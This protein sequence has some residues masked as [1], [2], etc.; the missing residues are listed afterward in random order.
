DRQRRART[1]RRR[2]AGDRPARAGARGIQQGA[3][4]AGRGRAFAAAAGTEAAGCRWPRVR[5]GGADLTMGRTTMMKR[6]A[7]LAVLVLA[8]A[9][10][11]T[12]KG[13]FGGKDAAA[14]KAAEPAELVDF[15]ATLRPVK[16]WSVGLGD[17]ERRMGAR[18]GPAV[19]D[20]RVY[21]A[22]AEGVV[23]AL[24]L[25]TGKEVWSHKT[26]KDERLRLS[27]GPGTG[28]GLV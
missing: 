27:G 26:A 24:D 6:A 5:P 10:C 14:K 12:I 17:G 19:A 16:L 2:A 25:Q 15:E 23:F 7:I 18:Q 13:W 11:S 28:D 4:R 21:A 8:L 1:A 22:A 3:D 9:G 20:G